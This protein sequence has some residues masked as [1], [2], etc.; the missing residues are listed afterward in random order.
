MFYISDNS[1]GIFL[2]M[3]QKEKYIGVMFTAFRDLQGSMLLSQ[4]LKNKTECMP[5]LFQAT[6]TYPDLMEKPLI[7]KGP[8]KL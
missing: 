4:Y 6:V 7:Q 1:K 2:F 3:V 5:Y 8:V